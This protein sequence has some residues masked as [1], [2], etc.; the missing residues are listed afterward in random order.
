MFQ[1]LRWTA[2]GL[3]LLGGVTLV[4]TRGS[5]LRN[6]DGS[7]DGGVRDLFT[8]SGRTDARLQL[9]QPDFALAARRNNMVF[10]IPSP[11]FGGGLIESI[12]EGVLLAN[13]VADRRLK[14]GPGYLRVRKSGGQ[15]QNDHPLWL[16]SSKQ[17]TSHVRGRSLQRRNRRD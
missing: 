10:R 11:T 12:P 4:A 2:M 15:H 9:A 13:K 1:W 8:I 16:E 3:T 7:S 17:V 14:Q 6:P 5:I